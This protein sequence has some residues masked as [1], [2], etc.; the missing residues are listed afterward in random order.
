M[1]DALL[2]PKAHYERRPVFRKDISRYETDCCAGI[3]SYLERVKLSRRSLH[4]RP[5]SCL[6]YVVNILL[7]FDYFV[8]ALDIYRNIFWLNDSPELIP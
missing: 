3:G 6:S 2:Y 4:G 8:N 5:S 7:G 1:D